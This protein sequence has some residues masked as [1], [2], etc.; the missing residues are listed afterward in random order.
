[1]KERKKEEFSLNADVTAAEH[2][3]QLKPSRDSLH[4]S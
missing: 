1:M 2:D 3:T 4:T